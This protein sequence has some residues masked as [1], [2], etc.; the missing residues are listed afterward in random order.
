MAEERL[1]AAQHARRT[2]GQAVRP[3]DVVRTRQVK[4]GLRDRLALVLK[5]VAGVGAQN[6]FYFWHVRTVGCDVID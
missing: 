5:Q 1:Q 4:I 6:L 2:V 3:L